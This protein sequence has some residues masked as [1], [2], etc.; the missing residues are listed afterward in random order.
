MAVTSIWDVKGRVATVI[1][2]VANPQ[3]TSNTDYKEVA[4]FHR[5]VN[6]VGT[7][8][9]YTADQMKTE[10][11]LYCTGINC[12][13]DPKLATKQFGMTKDVYGKQGGIVCYHGYQSFKRR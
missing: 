13:D 5:I 8:I 4:S 3:K 11:Q 6:S 12:S 9:E 10:K 2:Y 1:K 7:V